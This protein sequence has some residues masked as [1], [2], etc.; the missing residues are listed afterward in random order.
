MGNVRV[1][2]TDVSKQETKK[3]ASKRDRKAYTRDER[4]AQVLGALVVARNEGVDGLTARGIAEYLHITA[5]THL[6]KLLAEM[7][8][9]REIIFIREDDPGI[10]GFRL[11][12][13]LPTGTTTRDVLKKT[14][15]YIAGRKVET[16]EE[17]DSRLMLAITRANGQKEMFS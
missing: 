11:V 2:S 14:K 6:R 5:S 13:M 8:A 17:R 15:G 1:F 3:M 4:K 12:Y 10:A 9:Q 16:K 7:E